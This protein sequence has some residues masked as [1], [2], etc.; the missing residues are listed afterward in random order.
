MSEQTLDKRV[1]A[2]AKMFVQKQ[3]PPCLTQQQ[4]QNILEIWRLQQ[5]QVHQKHG[6]TVPFAVEIHCDSDLSIAVVFV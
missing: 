1:T 6:L 2:K 5:Q 4:Q 3:H